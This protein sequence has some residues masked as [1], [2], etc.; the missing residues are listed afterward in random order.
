M[1]V[2]HFTLIALPRSVNPENHTEDDFL[3]S[4]HLPHLFLGACQLLPKFLEI[5]READWLVYEPK[6][7]STF[8][9]DS[10]PVLPVLK[11]SSAVRF[12]SDPERALIDGA[13]SV[14]RQELDK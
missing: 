13:E 5:V 8:E 12:I 11:G 3:E 6:S 2:H 10:A 1:G 7:K 9:P 14:R 4:H